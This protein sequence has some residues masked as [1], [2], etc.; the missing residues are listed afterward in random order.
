MVLVPW[1]L[2]R[3]MVRIR[4]ERQ[5]DQPTPGQSWEVGR[6]TQSPKS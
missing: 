5:N 6:K 3:A 2:S 1:K 4:I